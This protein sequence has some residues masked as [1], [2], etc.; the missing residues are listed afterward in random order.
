MTDAKPTRPLRVPSLLREFL[1][2]SSAG[3]VV[4]MGSAALA[5]VVANSPL[6]PAYFEA[7]HLHLAGLSLL[8]WINDGLMAVFFLMVGLEI[9]R[10]ML[11]GQLATWG[12]RALPGAAAA[13]RHG[14][15]GADLRGLQPGRCR[16]TLRGWAIPAATDIAF[17]LGVLALLGRRVPDLAQDLSRRRSPSST[18]SGRWPSSPPSTPQTCPC[19]FLGWPPWPCSRCWPGSTVRA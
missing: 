14:R 15:A 11:D 16:T 7:L 19:S 17:A 3:G 10:E 5:L 9:K 13:R 2:S 8:H 6:A 12:R 1:N 18:T 4:L